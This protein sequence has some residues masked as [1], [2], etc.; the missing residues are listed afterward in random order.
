[1]QELLAE[2]FGKDKLRYR[3]NPDEAVAIGASLLAHNLG[4]FADNVGDNISIQNRRIRK[5]S[6]T[7]S[8]TKLIDVH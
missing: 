4:E 2:K 3:I 5:I 7:S 1:M 6:T 8:S